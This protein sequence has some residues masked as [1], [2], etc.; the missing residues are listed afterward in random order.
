ML[1]ITPFYSA[2]PPEMPNYQKTAN[3]LFKPEAAASRPDSSTGSMRLV[4]RRGV[5]VMCATT[6]RRPAWRA[7][8]F[9]STEHVEN[10]QD[11]G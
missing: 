8:T 5:P 2:T 7:G 3:A 11:F 6:P 9:D 4:T 1:E 10:D